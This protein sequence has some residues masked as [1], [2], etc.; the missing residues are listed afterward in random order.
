MN[1]LYYEF[2]REI[3]AENNFGKT[4]LFDRR[5]IKR[6]INIAAELA[7]NPGKSLAGLFKGWYDTK[8]IYNLL[9]LNIMTPDVI[10]ENHRTVVRESISNWNEDILL[11]EDSSE[12]EWNHLEPIEGL[13]PIGSGREGDQGFI[14]HSTLAV[15]ITS[16]SDGQISAKILGLPY[17]QYYV[18]PP[19]RRSKHGRDKKNNN[20]ET[21]LW[22]KAILHDKLPPKPKHKCIRVCDRNADIYEVFQETQASGYNHIIRGKH[23]RA[24]SEDAE[25]KAFKMLR[26]LPAIGSTLIE[27]R[28]R[29]NSIKRTISLNINWQEVLLR[30][31]ARPGYRIGALPPLKVTLIH[32]W[33][34]DPETQELIEWF[35]YTDLIINDFSFAC[36]VVKYYAFR[37]MIEDYHK[38]LK[39]GLKAERL[40]LETAH[41][42]F[43]AIAIMSIV[44]LRL[45]DLREALREDPDAPA[46]QSGLDELEIKVLGAYLEREIKTVK[47]VAL[48]IGK[49]GGHLNRK[50]DGMPGFMTLWLGMSKLYSLV[51]GVK[52]M[53]LIKN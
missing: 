39:S 45:I 50:S 6:L 9:S 18:R 31:P 29:K 20:I 34:I 24:D 30:A 44:A 16:K 35:L 8:A 38:A 10:Q 14:L 26:E 42:L 51:E 17:Q 49:L 28:G 47:C 11:I 27:R 53:R 1:T 3:W 46:E 21:D 15:G 52:L 4:R 48:A 33:G 41:S 37:W 25:I 2:D 12:F 7:K 32:V 13:G 36:T 5:R 43:A 40:Q 23:D 22:R 19:V